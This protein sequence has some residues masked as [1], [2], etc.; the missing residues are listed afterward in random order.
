M[1]RAT[2]ISMSALDFFTSDALDCSWSRFQYCTWYD[3]RSLFV[4][5]HIMPSD[6]DEYDE[7]TRLALVLV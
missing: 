7:Q 3:T 6:Y 5:Q 2:V 1:L 4:V